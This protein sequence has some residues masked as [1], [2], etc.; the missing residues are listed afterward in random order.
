MTDFD[1]ELLV[2]RWVWL[3]TRHVKVTLV[4]GARSITSRKRACRMQVLLLCP[5]STDMHWPLNVW[6]LSS[7]PSEDFKLKSKFNFYQLKLV[8]TNRSPDGAKNGLSCKSSRS[9]RV[10][11]MRTSYMVNCSRRA[12]SCRVNNLKISRFDFWNLRPFNRKY[13][14]KL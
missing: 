12:T 8:S 13:L 6:P 4:A 1:A 5:A 2:F 11:D 10:T 3:K 14:I 9:I 7:R